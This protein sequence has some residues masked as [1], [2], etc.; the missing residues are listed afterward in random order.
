MGV[1]MVPPLCANEHAQGLKQAA[2]SASK[3]G[4]QIDP[5]I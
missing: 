2:Q 1:R 5:S 3:Y 4:S